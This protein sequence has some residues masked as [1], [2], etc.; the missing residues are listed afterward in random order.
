MGPEEPDL[1]DAGHT[2]Q[3]REIMVRNVMG[4]DETPNRLLRSE[5]PGLILG[6]G[7]Q[8]ALRSLA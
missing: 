6:V 8:R 4:D 5:A 7:G 2:K 3:V 1:P